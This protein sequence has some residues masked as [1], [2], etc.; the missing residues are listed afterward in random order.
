MAG[1]ALIAACGGSS[2]R[3]CC[4]TS[5]TGPAPSTDVQAPLAGSVTKT[6]AAKNASFSVDYAGSDGGPLSSY[7]GSGIADFAAD[8]F[9]LSLQLPGFGTVEER[10]I[11]NDVYVKGPPIENLP[12]QKPWSKVSITDI[13]ANS[14]TGLDLESENPAQLLTTLRGITGAITKVGTAEVRGVQATHY[15]ADV[16]YAKAVKASGS[17]SA[18][19]DQF[20][21]SLGIGSVPEDVY[22]D[23]DGLVRRLSVTIKPATLPST[24]PGAPS[25]PATVTT[26]TVD[27][28]DFGT[29]DVSDIT[30]P[31]SGQ[32]GPSTGPSSGSPTG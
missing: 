29:T 10:V 24:L 21:K 3:S 9:Q 7:G 22:V 12:A 27:L 8:K 18:M 28:Y 26:M 32:V 15:R 20:A 11:G 4:D 6:L 13:S 5:V 2:A 30:A 23:R 17:D 14:S 1:G 31:P 25:L 19:L 16:D